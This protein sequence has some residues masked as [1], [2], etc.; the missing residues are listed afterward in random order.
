V[1]DAPTAPDAAPPAS[2]RSPASRFLV[3]GI[4]LFLAAG[5]FYLFAWPGFETSWAID[6]LGSTHA[7]TKQDARQRLKD[8]ADAATDEA[9][10]DAVGDADR[11][12]RVRIECVGLLLEKNRLTAIE[13][14]A[15]SGD[16]PTRSVIYA[17]LVRH[18]FFRNEILPD[19]T[20]RVADTVREWLADSSSEGRDLAISLAQEL[21]IPD[22][23]QHIRPLLV[24]SAAEGAGRRFATETLTAA[25]SAVLRY[26]DC[27]SVPQV[28]A[29]AEA[30][31]DMHVRMRAWD[32][33]EPLVLG[34]PSHPAVCPGALPPERVGEVLGKMLESGGD[35]PNAHVPRMRAAILISRHPEHMA[36]FGARIRAMLDGRGK[37]AERRE[38][39]AALVAAKDAAI[40]PDLPRFA[41]DRDFEVRHAVAEWAGR[42]EGLAAP[43]LWIGLLRDETASWDAV[44]LAHLNLKLQAGRFVGLPD[45]ITKLVGEPD[46]Q[47]VAIHDFLQ[48]MVRNGSFE[49]LSRDAWAEAW[50]RWYA[51]SQG[52]AG[53]TLEQAVAVRK[54]FRAAMDRGDAPA[55]KKALEGAPTGEGSGRLWLYE[56]GWLASR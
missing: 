30:D 52:L 38:A 34:Y 48:L 29:L 56:E 54:A 25:I 51:E 22:V 17:E 20:Y 9:L 33:L 41:H 49:G 5:A 11:P 6:G 37:P 18:S 40:G 26:G 39:L 44:R 16:R 32:A 31:P 21:E 12:F 28:V 1:S 46:K 55:A 2:R 3:F 53:E 19:P 13:A 10:L 24:R 35:G 50:F 43:S 15:R 7:E 36:A 47:D 23:M 4:P 8:R 14:L 27:E 42:L 45:S